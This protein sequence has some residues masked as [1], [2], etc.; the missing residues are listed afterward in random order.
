[1]RDTT[2]RRWVATA[3][4]ALTAAWAAPVAGQLGVGEAGT[5]LIQGGT[6]VVTPG[7]EIANGS[8]LIQDGRIVAVGSSVQAPAGA[9]VIDASGKWV[10]PGMI[11]A[12]TSMGLQEIG[13][14]A[15]MNMNTEIGDYNPHNRAIIAM[16]VDSEM[17]GITRVNGITNVITAPGGG[18]MSGQAAMIHLAG[19]TWEEM[20]VLEPAAF[21]IN[22]P[23]GG[24][25]GRGGFGGRFGGAGG[26]SA[27]ERQAGLHTRLREAKDYEEARTAGS[28]S[29][30][31]QYE[32]M[33]PLMRGEVPALVSVNTEE[34]IRNVVAFQE[35]YGIR[36][37]VNGG[38][39][40]WKVAEFLAENDVPVVL[41]SIQ[42]TPGQ[43]DPYDAIYAAP[44]VLTEAGVKI[45]FST[46]GVSGV[47]HVP[48]HAQLA[49]GYGL[50][51]DVA[52][53][54]L[55]IWPAEMFGVDGMIGT[56]EE[57]KVANLFVTSGDPLDI[58][59]VV[60]EVF[61]EGRLL[62]FDDR[63]SQLYEKYDS[64]GGN[65]GGN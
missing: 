17:I 37:I 38:R 32:A 50:P 2:M 31:L 3:A 51:K 21:V 56:I 58:R 61:V 30:D 11:N 20:T 18:I 14:I 59:S 35:Q 43:N 54:A 26:P 16:N 55:T 23:S 63:H 27:E 64:R 24:G 65:T 41:G 34:D 28:S 48:F 10:F 36:V 19:W 53:R 44:A 46:G 52:H 40:A 7:Q 39:E 57:G 49:V 62:P 60:S 47:R 29:F 13:R 5:Y 22:Y 15:T 42:S 9:T 12:S 33:R 4:F 6:V 45:A 25:G 1:M 8:V